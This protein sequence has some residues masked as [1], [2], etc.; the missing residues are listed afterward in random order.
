MHKSAEE[1]VLEYV[2]GDLG[3]QGSSLCGEDAVE[4][5]V[6]G[7]ASDAATS[8]TKVAR[9][10]EAVV[11]DLAETAAWRRWAWAASSAVSHV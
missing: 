8:W 5:A 2:A 9:C 7:A 11:K 1:V 10:R 3:E 4:D 6:V